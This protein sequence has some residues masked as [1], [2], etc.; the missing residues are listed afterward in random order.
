MEERREGEERGKRK[1][2]EGEGGGESENREVGT[3]WRE[4]R[5]ERR[6]EGGNR[7]RTIVA[8]K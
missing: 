1:V 4:Q 6:R 3:R 2:G 5:R 8:S 7:S